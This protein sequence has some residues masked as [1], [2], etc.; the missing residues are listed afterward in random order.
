RIVRAR[1]KRTSTATTAMTINATNGSPSLVDQCGCTFDLDHL[2][3]RARLD[4]LVG[5]VRAC[6]PFLA[7][8]TDASP[9]LV[10]PLEDDCLR[11]LQGGGAGADRR[12][13]AQMSTR[14][15]TQEADRRDRAGDE[16]DE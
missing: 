15:R 13:H 7:A 14:D 1:T 6:R 12:G 16:D 2:D 8:D 3:A 10:H 4:H 9:V 11:S 5:H